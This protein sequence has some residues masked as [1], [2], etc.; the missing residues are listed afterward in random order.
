MTRDLIIR[1]F[2]DQ[3]HE[4]LGRLAS[5]KGVSMNSIVR[6]AVDRWLK[7]QKVIPKKHYLVI[8]SDDESM[9]ALLKSMDRLAKEGD[10]FRCFCGPPYSS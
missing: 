10:L 3:V 7:D 1:G 6:D 5:Q 4:D 2:D 9:I 8:Y